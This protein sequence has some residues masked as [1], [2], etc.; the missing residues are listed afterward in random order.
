MIGDTATLGSHPFYLQLIE[1][2][3][4]K[5]FYKSSFEFPT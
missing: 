2:V 4:E 1:Y 5:G 3:Q